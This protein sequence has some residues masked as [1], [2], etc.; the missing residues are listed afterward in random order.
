MGGEA[1]LVEERG[2]A[3]LLGAAA[4]GGDEG[5]VVADGGRGVGKVAADESLSDEDVAR[6]GG[7][8]A[9]VVAAAS[10]DDDEAV[11]GDLLGGADESVFAVPF[12]GTA[13]R[14]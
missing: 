13:S 14:A 5:D 9:G 11:E 10:A 3:R 8:D 4:D 1:V 12:S 2:V 6:G 7:V